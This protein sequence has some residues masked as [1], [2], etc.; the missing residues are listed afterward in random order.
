MRGSRKSENG[1][2]GDGERRGR[3]KKMKRR[4][5]EDKEGEKRTK[6]KESGG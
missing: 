4:G 6:S 3:V 1:G 2:E 5:K